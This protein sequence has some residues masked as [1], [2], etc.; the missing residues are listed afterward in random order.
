MYIML[1]IYILFLYR[2][3]L[4]KNLLAYINLHLH[5]LYK[6]VKLFIYFIIY[7][8]KIDYSFVFRCASW[9]DYN[10]YLQTCYLG[11]ERK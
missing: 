10:I 7:K 9:K 3:A 2:V 5:Q 1:C 4:P 6:Q 11:F 8:K